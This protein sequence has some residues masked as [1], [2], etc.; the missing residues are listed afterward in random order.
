MS[1]S[2]TDDRLRHAAAAIEAQR[3]ATTTGPLV[4]LDD[5]VALVERRGSVE[6]RLQTLDAV[7]RDPASRRDFELL[8]ALAS[9]AADQVETAHQPTRRLP[10]MLAVL[11]AAAVL[12]VVAM[13][14][15][16]RSNEPVGE[17]GAMRDAEGATT[18]IGPPA[19]ATMP[20]ARRFVWHAAAEA[21]RYRFE[22]LTADGL[23][24]FTTRTTDTLLVLPD[25]VRLVAGTEYRWWVFSERSDGT[26]RASPFRRLM[27]RAAP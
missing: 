22:I 26:H 20:D 1:R 23:P 11:A 2:W 4:T 8:R 12:G 5:I 24:L 21:Q 27:V 16:P 15:T 9:G 7:M 17:T 13:P 19:N 18:L 25:D 3:A 14:F 6:E 10:R